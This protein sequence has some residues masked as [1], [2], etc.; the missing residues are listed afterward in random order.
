MNQLKTNLPL[1]ALFFLSALVLISCNSNTDNR[2]A[3]QTEV[4]AVSELTDPGDE[5]TPSEE[6]EERSEKAASVARGIDI[7]KYQGDE[8]A[9]LNK[10]KDALS[11]IICKATEGVTFTDPDFIMNWKLIPSTW[12]KSLKYLV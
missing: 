4:G 2:P 5:V 10:H 11:F 6:R 7:S 12:I 8:V 1:V 9:M 3:T